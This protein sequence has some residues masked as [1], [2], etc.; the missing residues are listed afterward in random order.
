MKTCEVPTCGQKHH[1]R[2]FCRLHYGRLRTYG[3]A[4]RTK[5][6]RCGVKEPYDQ[7][8]ICDDCKAGAALVSVEAK[9]CSKCF[10]EKPISQFMRAWVSAGVPKGPDGHQGTCKQCMADGQRERRANN[11]HKFRAWDK[12]K[13][14]GYSPE[15]KRANFLKY[16]HSIT[17]EK[18][19][20]MYDAQGGCCAICKVAAD[21][22]YIDH[23][24]ECCPD[25]R[26]K[27][28]GRC[29]RALLCSRCNLALGNF[30]DSADLMR[31]AIEYV[32][33]H[34]RNG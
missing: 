17:V 33:F 24:H 19:D 22:L 8:R 28:C 11:P 10:V 3:T 20:E 18:Y 25:G 4:E 7:N 14:A 34:R 31:A 21:R 6:I 12:T 30:D 13:R 32:E 15:A 1:C 2:G 29:V 23:D 16:H 9:V 27:K 26:K 5:C